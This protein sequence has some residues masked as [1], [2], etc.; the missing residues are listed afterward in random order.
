MFT[1]MGICCFVLRRWGFEELWDFFEF[2]CYKSV[3]VR[4]DRK[5]CNLAG[6]DMVEMRFWKCA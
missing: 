4:V 1:H 5:C 3:C 6:L 2:G